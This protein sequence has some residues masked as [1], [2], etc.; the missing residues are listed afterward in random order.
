[1]R[2]SKDCE[3][4]GPAPDA[5][6]TISKIESDSKELYEALAEARRR[7]TELRESFVVSE[8]LLRGLLDQLTDQHNDHHAKLEESLQKAENNSSAIRRQL[9]LVRELLTTREATNGS[10]SRSSSFSSMET[11]VDDLIRNVQLAPDGTPIPQLTPVNVSPRLSQSDADFP[12]NS[13]QSAITMTPASPMR[14]GHGV[15]HNWADANDL[16]LGVS[17][18][19]YRAFDYYTQAKAAYDACVTCGLVGT[20]VLPWNPSTEWFVL[21]IGVSPGIHQRPTLMHAIG[22]ANF[23][24]LTRDNIKLATSKEQAEAVWHA[25]LASS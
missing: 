15:F 1:M 6:E 4:S 10:R 18:P 20:L 24:K 12:S 2:L 25:S 21:F 8:E 11:D 16:V 3:G 7:Q 19:M 13:Q 17:N 5:A 22:L 23:E 14:R 9:D